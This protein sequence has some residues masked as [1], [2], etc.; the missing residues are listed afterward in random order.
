[1]RFE[2]GGRE[3][4]QSKAHPRLPRYKHLHYLPRFGRYFNEKFNCVHHVVRSFA[5]SAAVWPEVQCPTMIHQFD[6]RLGVRANLLGR[7]WYQSKCRPHIP[8]RFLYTLGG[9]RPILHRLA[10]IRKSAGRKRSERLSCRVCC[11]KIIL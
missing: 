1:M 11:L 4:H 2:L 10:T 6:L 5:L 8:M 9:Y 3:L 7:K